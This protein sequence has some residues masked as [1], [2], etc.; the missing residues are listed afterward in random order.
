LHYSDDIVNDKHIHLLDDIN[1][2]SEHNINNVSEH[3]LP[4]VQ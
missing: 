4:D 2:G 1:N 3:G